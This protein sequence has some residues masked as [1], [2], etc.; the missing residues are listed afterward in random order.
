[1]I[2]LQ[3]FARECGVTDRTI[4]K[5][6]KNH[7]AELTG[8]YQRRGKNGTWLDEEAQDFIRGLMIQQPVVV[9]DME[10]YR[11]NQQLK[12]EKEELLEENRRLHEAM[13]NLNKKLV[14]AL[15]RE[16]K[17]AKQLAEA[18]AKQLLL[19]QAE[20]EADTQR[21]RAEAAEAELSQYQP[22]AFGLYRKK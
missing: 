10:Q 13:E 11:E 17:Q 12:A 19:Q 14:A 4:Q 20:L 2:K 21:Q 9:G 8:H 7:E 6:L 5:H 3:D 16:V 22:W 15:E 18:D 1:M